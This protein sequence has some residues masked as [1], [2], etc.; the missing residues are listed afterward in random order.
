MRWKIGRIGG[1]CS[2]VECQ[3]DGLKSFM[4][5]CFSVPNSVVNAC[6]MLFLIFRDLDIDRCDTSRSGCGA[7]V[8]DQNSK[9]VFFSCY[10][11]T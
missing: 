2:N 9:N 4:C 5:T 8:E 11:Y 7:E 1:G 3:Q 10:D 6:E